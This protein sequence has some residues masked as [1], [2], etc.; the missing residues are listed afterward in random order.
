MDRPQRRLAS[1]PFPPIRV[2]R[3]PIAI[4]APRSILFCTQ[5]TLQLGSIS[6]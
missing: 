2:A 1:K 6:Y 3:T 4:V 5:Q